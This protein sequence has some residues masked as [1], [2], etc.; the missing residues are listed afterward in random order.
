MFIVANIISADDT[1]VNDL[2]DYLKLLKD[3][4]NDHDMF[5]KVININIDYLLH[6]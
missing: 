4:D 3:Y 6:L 5:H 1:E 2:N